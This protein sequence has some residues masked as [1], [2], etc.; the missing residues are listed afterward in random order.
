M[1]TYSTA[2]HRF[3]TPCLWLQSAC[4]LCCILR[5]RT[6]CFYP[7]R[8]A[9]PHTKQKWLTLTSVQNPP[10]MSVEHELCTALVVYL[11]V[12]YLYTGHS[13]WDV[14]TYYRILSLFLSS[15]VVQSPPCTSTPEDCFAVDNLTRNNRCKLNHYLEHKQYVSCKQFITQSYCHILLQKYRPPSQSKK[16]IFLGLSEWITIL[17]NTRNHSPTDTVSHS[18][19]LLSTRDITKSLNL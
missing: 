6:A 15:L 17:Q 11:E 9:T 5:C 18:G 10:A 7:V 16:N 4:S 13:G 3:L 19:R 1:H 2:V 12:C 8:S 14:Q